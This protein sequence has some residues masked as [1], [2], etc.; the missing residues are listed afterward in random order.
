M[1]DKYRFSLW[2]GS[3]TLPE[4]D[5]DTLLSALADDL[6][7]HGDLEHALRSLMQR[8][9]RTP[10]MNMRGITDFVKQLREERKKRLERYDLGGVMDDVQRQLKEILELERGQIDQWRKEGTDDSNASAQPSGDG[11]ESSTHDS[12]ANDATDAQQS[13]PDKAKS[14]QPK[15]SSDQFSQ[16]LLRNIANDKQQFLDQLP[17]DPAGQ[18]Q[19]L[20]DYEFLSPEA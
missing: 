16:N 2:D 3:Q 18:V 19:K 12:S 9:M 11:S 1:N 14:K 15:S 13:S 7:N 20:Q 17:Q 6:L 8:G 4:L 10:Q 5:A